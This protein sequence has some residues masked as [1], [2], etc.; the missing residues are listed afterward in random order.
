MNS[1]GLRQFRLEC[2][3]QQIKGN[4]KKIVAK[5]NDS[6][7]ESTEICDFLKT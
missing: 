4:F 7:N 6:K 3:L 1:N 5:T 2:N